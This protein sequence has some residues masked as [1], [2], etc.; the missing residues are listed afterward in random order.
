MFA[1][2]VVEMDSFVEMSNEARL[3]YFYLGLYTDDDGF[4]TIHQM[5]TKQQPM[6]YQMTT[7]RIPNII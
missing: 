5:T 6:V 4:I 2:D 1:P 3:L 7:K